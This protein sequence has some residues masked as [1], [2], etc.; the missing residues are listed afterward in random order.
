MKP[1][2]ITSQET[3]HWLTLTQAARLLGVHSI[4]LRRWADSGEIRCLRTPGGHRRFLEEDLR[5]FLDVRGQPSL[6]QAPEAFVRSLILQTRQ[7]M[8]ARSISRESWHA[9][10]DESDRIARRESGQQLLG[11]SLIHI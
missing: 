3:F 11:L 2:A 8:A 4:T 9:A 5:A 10:F 1:D 7:E 6:P